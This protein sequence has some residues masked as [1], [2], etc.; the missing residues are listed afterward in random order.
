MDILSEIIEVKKQEV[1]NLIKKYSYNSFN[2]YEYFNSDT[3]NFEK[4]LKNEKRISVIAEIKKASPSKGIISQNFN[5]L[6][7]AEIYNEQNVDA[8]SVLTDEK[9]FQGNIH[10]ISEIKKATN[11]PLLR[12]DFI[13]DDYQILEAKAFGADAILLI[14]EALSSTQI[15]D[16]TDCAYDLN[17]AV[18]L[19]L[20]SEE[21]LSKI[22][23]NKNR[24]LGINNRDLKNFNVDLT[25]TER[26]KNRIEKNVLIVSESGISSGKN[27]S[28][29]K[30]FGVN[31]VLVGE[32]FMKS[33][34]LKESLMQFLE[35][36]N[37]EN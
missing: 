28:Y 12:K 15:N 33:E 29:L 32:H 16:L 11:L 35:W 17:L 19:E 25:T 23:F 7:I 10:F 3:R 22:D 14:S 18:L 6:Q 30:N 2:S 20:H 37:Y 8:I 13:I 9:F 24:I 4:A 26:I 34:N 1:R 5:H 27:I 21:Q 36:C 31:A